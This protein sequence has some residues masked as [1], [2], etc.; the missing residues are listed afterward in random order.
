MSTHPAY[1]PR[2][3]I[4]LPKWLWTTVLAPLAVAGVLASVAW[5]WRQASATSV[6]EQRVTTNER[7]IE[8]MDEKLDRIIELVSKR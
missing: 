1:S 4:G 2:C 3:Y 8:R 7:V 6:L 5:A